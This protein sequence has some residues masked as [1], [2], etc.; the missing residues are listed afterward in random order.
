MVVWQALAVLPVNCRR[1]RVLYPQVLGR[2]LDRFEAV[3]LQSLN[4]GVA[5]LLRH[6]NV[7]SSPVIIVLHIYL[8]N[9][10]FIINRSE[11]GTGVGH[12]LI[13]RQPNHFLINSLDTR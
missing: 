2:M 12:V 8:Q 1:A 5:L 9:V 13:I 3:L 10:N 11:A 4:Q 7:V 6:P